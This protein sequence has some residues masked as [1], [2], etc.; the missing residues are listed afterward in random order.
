MESH[1]L[2]DL[3]YYRVIILEYVGGYQQAM[4]AVHALMPADEARL[5]KV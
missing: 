5:V 4:V 3:K 2:L 1:V